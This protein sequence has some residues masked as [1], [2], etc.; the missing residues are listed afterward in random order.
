MMAASEPWITLHRDYRGALRLLRDPSREV[1][2]ARQ[3]DQV[4]GFIIL[5][6]QSPL[7]GYIQTVG[8]MPRQRGR[9]I[10]SRLVRFAEERIFRESPNVFLCVSSFNTRA[11]EFYRR[12]GYDVIGRIEDFVVAGHA[13]I[14]LRKTTGPWIDEA[15]S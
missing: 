9:G 11:Q 6:L 15:A 2:V 13:E 12:L 3:H 1:Y 5:L 8:V 10:G 7:K 4:V 14:L